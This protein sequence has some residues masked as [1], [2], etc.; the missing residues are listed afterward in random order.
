[1]HI[2]TYFNKEKFIVKREESLQDGNHFCSKMYSFPHL[3]PGMSDIELELDCPQELL[4]SESQDTR[5]GTSLLNSV[6]FT[7]FGK[8]WCKSLGRLV[9]KMAPMTEQP[10]HTVGRRINVSVNE[11]EKKVSIMKEQLAPQFHQLVSSILI[12]RGYRTRGGFKRKQ[13]PSPESKPKI[14]PGL[15]SAGFLEKRRVNP[16]YQ[17]PKPGKGREHQDRPNPYKID[18]RTDPRRKPG[19]ATESL[20]TKTGSPNNKITDADYGTEL[21][22]KRWVSLRPVKIFKKSEELV[23]GI[24]P[25]GYDFLHPGRPLQERIDLLVDRHEKENSPGLRRRKIKN[26]L[27]R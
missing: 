24:W 18:R 19:V 11:F 8:C 7:P 25:R 3:I 6:N 21:L 9:E 22:K 14:I 16:V 4:E 12:D 27:R 1:M 2:L 26:I 20:A 17:Q 23:E 5:P 10:S 15:Y 13:E